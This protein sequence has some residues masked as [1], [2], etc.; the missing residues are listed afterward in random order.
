MHFKKW[1]GFLAHPVHIYRTNRK[2]KKSKISKILKKS[3]SFD[4]FE[5]IPECNVMS[6]NPQFSA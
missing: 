1:S 4:I 5:D 6:S 3:D 2:Y